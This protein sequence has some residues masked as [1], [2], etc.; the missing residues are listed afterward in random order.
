MF[1]VVTYCIEK[2]FKKLKK[3]FFSLCFRFRYTFELY[4]TSEKL[5]QF[6]LETPDALHSWAKAIGKVSIK[7]HDSVHPASDLNWGVLMSSCLFRPPRLWAATAYWRGSLSVWACCVIRPCWTRGSGKRASLFCKSPTSSF[8]LEMME[9]LR[10]LLTW[11]ACRS[12]VSL[13][14]PLCFRWFCF[15]FC[16][17]T[18]G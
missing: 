8:A 4:L 5:V 6:G 14:S 15:I 12:S 13:S 11:N 18:T 17:V 7:I 10:I 9:L 16:A 1:S 3:A 2:C